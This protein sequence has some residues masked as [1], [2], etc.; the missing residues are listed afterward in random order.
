MGGGGG[1]TF[2]GQRQAIIDGLT[3]ARGETNQ[4]NARVKPSLAVTD[5]VRTSA[6]LVTI[7]LPAVATYDITAN[8]TITA[9]IPAAA[10]VQ[11]G[12]GIMA[13][14]TFQ[15][16]VAAGTVALT[17]T[18]DSETDIRAGGSTILL[19]LTDDT[20]VTAFNPQRQAIIDGL[21]SAQGET[22]GWNARV[23]PALAVKDVVRTSATLVTITLP[24]VATYDI[25]AAETITATIPAAALAQSGTG[26]VAAPTFQV[27]VAAGTAALTGTDDSETDIQAGGSTILLT[28]TDD[29]WVT[30]FNPQRQAIID[31]LTS[32]QGETNGWNA[33]VKPALAV[34]D[35]VRTSATLVT[36]TLPAVATYDITAAETIT[37]TI[38]AAALVQSGTGI[39]AAPTFQVTVA[40]GTAALTVTDDSE[41]DIQ[42]GGSTILLTLTDDTWVT[43]FNA[44]RQAIIDGLTSAQGET[45]GWNARVKP[46]LAVK[47]VVR[48]SATLVTITLPA[49]ATYDI[50]ATET[51]T[52]T[53]PAALV[54]SGTGIVVAPTFQVTVAAGTAALTGTVT[55]DSETD[56]RADGSTILLTLTDDTWVTAFNAQRQAIIDGLT[57]AQ[58]ETNGWNARVKPALAV[59]DVVR[60]SATLVTIT[61]PAVATYDITAAETITATIPAALAQSGTGIVAAPT[62]QVTVAAGTAALTV[63]DDSETDI[64]AGG[65]TILLTLTDDTWVTAFNAQRQ[66]IIDGLTSAQGETNGWN[67][68]VKPALAVTDV[69]R[70]SATLVT[71]TLPA[72]ATYDIAAAET[73][74]ATIPAAALAQSGTG[75][76]AA[77]TF[78]VTVAAG[79]AALTGTVTDDSETDIRAGGSTILLT[80]TDDTWVTGFN[81]QRRQAIIDGLTSAQGET[82]GWNARVKPALA[83]KDVVRTNATLVTITLPAVATYDITATETITATIPAALVQSGTGIVAAPTFQVTVVP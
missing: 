23:K 6:T 77:P 39:M 33:R 52:A 31:G 36:I 73:I 43:A 79:T 10:L 34:T 72:V 13:A 57:S 53:I 58:G 55:D 49:V 32:A 20:W 63:T 17:G 28:L 38:P 64:R 14:P 22:N 44:Q 68:R 66:A 41:T 70:T 59:T 46:A 60:T 65:S 50:T 7:T 80:L 78:Q 82:N 76:V 67:A 45:N 71:I 11:S 29:T 54:Q 47:D 48:T 74:T 37:A 4:W 61:L 56:I 75:I 26:I 69:V 2:D 9:T 8:E 12:T 62:F 16:T 19:T 27:T 40:A 3:S 21:T 18:D 81:P 1:A 51:I 42:A 83:V 30:A 25:P 5:V 15:V 24:A 35:V